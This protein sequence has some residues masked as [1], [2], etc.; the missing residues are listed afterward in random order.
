MEKEIKGYEG[1]YTISDDGLVYGLKRKKYLKNVKSER[2]MIVSLNKNG[3]A[4]MFY[5]HRLV[6]E[7]FCDNPLIKPHVNH[8]DHNR[9]NNNYTNLEWVTPKE[10]VLHHVT[11]V[12]YNKNT[13]TME[14]IEKTR[15]KL[16]KKVLC[17]I[18]NTVYESIGDFASVRKISISQASMKLNGVLKNNINA[19]LFT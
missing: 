17:L 15:A 2:Y 10:N 14:S 16:K 8:I 11:S 5:I 7:A 9:E 19:C 3:V 12:F 4:K 1:L 6:A 18:S 13:P